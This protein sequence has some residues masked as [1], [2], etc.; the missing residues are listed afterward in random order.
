MEKTTTNK[1]EH[2]QV[3]TIQATIWT[4]EKDGKVMKSVQ[5][6]KSY[7]DKEGQWQETDK[8]F[9]NDLPKLALVLQK[10]YEK[11]VMKSEE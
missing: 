10:C 1:P 2:I 11:L 3:G 9:V 6:K 5:L 8:Y 7:K 4:N